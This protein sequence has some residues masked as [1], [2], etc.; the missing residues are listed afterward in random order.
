MTRRID[1]PDTGADTELRACLGKPSSFIMVAGA[2]SG[3]TTSLVKGLDYL[4]RTYGP[5]LREEGQSIACITYTEVAKDEIFGDVGQDPLF[6]VSTIHSFLWTL[7]RPFQADIKMW[8]KRRIMEKLVELEAEK[9]GFGSRVQQK[10]RDKNLRTIEK[11]QEIGRTIDTVKRFRYE[12]A[13]NYSEGVLGHD[14]I[15]KIGAALLTERSLLKTIT[16]KKYPFLFVDESQDTVP[17]IVAAFKAVEA[18]ERGR[19]CLGF[20]G[21]SMQQ[22]YTTGIGKIER[23]TGW[24]EIKKPENFRCS[25]NVLSVVN[26]VR[27]PGDGLQQIGGRSELIDGSRVPVAG[28]AR[29]F[30]LPADGQRDANLLHVRKWLAKQN[31]DPLWESDSK[32]A[33][34]KI[35]VIVHRMAA[36]RLGFGELHAAF[37]DGA[38]ESL[39]TGFGE[40]TAW[41]L[42]PFL[43]AILPLVDAFESKRSFAVM[44]LLRE[45]CPRLLP[46]NLKGTENPEKL[47]AA[48]NKDVVELA[49]LMKSDG[50]ATVSDVLSH[51]RKTRLID[52]D[53]RLVDLLEG[54]TTSTEAE[55]EDGEDDAAATLAAFLACPAAQTRGYR[56]YIN[57]ESPYSTQQGIKGA[58]FERVLVVLDDEEGRH[59]QFS[60]D[61]YIGIKAL[62][63][64]D[65]KNVAD[66][67]DHSVA[68]T[69]RLFYVCCSRA[70]RD[71][72]VVL[73]TADVDAAV[74][75]LK[76]LGIFEDRCVHTAAELK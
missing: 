4:R 52:L 61:K 26:K 2:G 74:K 58:E 11:Y 13:S 53:P 8:V 38:P 37:S 1:K 69:R 19:F 28:T 50:A 31:K 35:L 25:T 67:K 15:L 56:T 21:D 34:V 7:V 18:Q 32:E 46:A 12:T 16:A 73:F 71:L 33:D 65:K 17:G 63:D 45:Y 72:A 68:R 10:T 75:K 60:Y 3:K 6:H 9:A 62:S 48:L 44:S 64:V 36:K 76:E 20:F 29:A 57:D 14:D 59:M 40:G 41:P 22:I 54:T 24:E 55:P 23:E 49:K 43:A 30:V 70:L 47:L 5:K 42:R 51:I 39:K 66:N 27:K